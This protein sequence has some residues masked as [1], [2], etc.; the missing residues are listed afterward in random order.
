MGGLDDIAWRLRL[1]WRKWRGIAEVENADEIPDLIQ[2][3]GAIVVAE[4]GTKKW[5]VFDCPCKSGHRVMLNI[6]SRRRPMWKLASTTPLTVAPSVDV[7][8]PERRCHYFVRQGRIE[9]VPSH[10]EDNAHV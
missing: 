8:R 3:R 6:D 5:L 2:G 7:L 4:D 10:R 1:P 9:W